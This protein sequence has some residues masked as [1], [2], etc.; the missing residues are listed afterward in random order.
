MKPFMEI[1]SIYN[2]FRQP[3][4]TALS[5]VGLEAL[6]NSV[7]LTELDENRRCEC[8]YLVDHIKS[9]HYPDL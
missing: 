5:Y 7:Q 4:I 1:K 3:T 2:Q 8:L 6:L 9:G